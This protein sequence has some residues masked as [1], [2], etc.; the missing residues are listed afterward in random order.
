ML[1]TTEEPNQNEYWGQKVAVGYP[2]LAVNIHGVDVQ[3]GGS[4]GVPEG[5]GGFK[6]QGSWRP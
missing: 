6:V 2:A 4:G 5:F 1:T 3:E